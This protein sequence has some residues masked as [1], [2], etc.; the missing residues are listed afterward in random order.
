MEFSLK[1]LKI[2]IIGGDKRELELFFHLR[3]MDAQVCMY[4]FKEGETPFNDINLARDLGESLRRSNVVITPLNGIEEEGL[5]YT[6]FFDGKIHVHD[7]VFREGIQPGTLF[8]AGYLNPLIKKG[9]QEKNVIVC[10]T[11]EM[12]EVSILNAIPTA[13]GAIQVAMMNTDIT[14]HNSQCFVLGYGRCG[15]VL[16]ETLKGLGAIVTVVARRSEVLAWIQASSMRPL[17]LSELAKGIKRA[18]MI[19]NT[20]PSVVVDGEILCHVKKD[21]LIIDLATYPGGIDFTAAER[22]GIKTIVLPGLPGKVAP[23]TAGKILCQVYPYL[24]ISALKGGK[25]LEFKRD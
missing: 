8:I 18:D 20:I 24:I 14:I 6:P 25:Y 13:E 17:L 19:F 3:K 23:K 9:L 22:M 1:G 5:I 10:E 4:G 12:D 2:M 21:V 11:R 15:R 16:A 7:A